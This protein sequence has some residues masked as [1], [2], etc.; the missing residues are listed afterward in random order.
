MKNGRSEWGALYAYCHAQLSESPFLRQ[1]NGF[2]ISA[3]E[4][5]EI[6]IA[7]LATFI[8]QTKVLEH[9]LGIK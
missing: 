3:E 7:T 5:D 9:A 8:G 1:E 4:P 6:E 2:E